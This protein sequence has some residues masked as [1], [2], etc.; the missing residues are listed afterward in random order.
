MPLDN[1]LAIAA[2][3]CPVTLRITGGLMIDTQT[4]KGVHV[5]P[6]TRRVRA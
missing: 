6:A 5:D 4:M 1:A 2:S 3:S